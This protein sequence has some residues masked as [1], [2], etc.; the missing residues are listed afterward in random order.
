[1]RKQAVGPESEIR[2]IALLFSPLK[3]PFRIRRREKQES[4]F[5]KFAAFTAWSYGKTFLATD[6][7][8]RQSSSLTSLPL[9]VYLRY[10]SCVVGSKNSQGEVACPSRTITQITSIPRTS[11][12]KQ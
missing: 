4:R 2:G 8:S 9:S 12:L 5:C 7:L 1:M 3:H 10:Y 11:G 6:S